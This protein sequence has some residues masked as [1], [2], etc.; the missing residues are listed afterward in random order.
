MDELRKSFQQDL[1]GVQNEIVKLAA[2]VTEALP[3][4]TEALLSSDLTEAQRIIDEDDAMDL[5]SVNVEEACLRILTLQNPMASDMRAVVTA[6]KLNDEYERSGDLVSN[7]CKGVRRLYGLELSPALR[8]LITQMSEEATRLLRLSVDAYVEGNAG[9]ASAL[10]D[11]DDRLDDL[12]QDYIQEIFDR[13]DDSKNSL[14][15]QQ[16]VQLALLGRFYERIGDH[17]VNVGERVQYMVNG[18]LPEHSAVAR[19]AMLSD[20]DAASPTAGSET[21]PD[22]QPPP[23]DSEG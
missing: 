8:G 5:V 22:E 15:L 11:I 4:A 20:D 16:A 18:W 10:D 19:Q 7:I 2:L 14:T 9:L 17:A 3:R 6:M 12:Q 1:T 21:A 13:E 23:V